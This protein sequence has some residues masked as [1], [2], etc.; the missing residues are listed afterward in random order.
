MHRIRSN[1]KSLILLILLSAGTLAILGATVLSVWYPLEALERIIPS[2]M[3]FLITDDE[4]K[5]RSL[6]ALDQAIGNEAY[7]SHE[8]TLLKV[9]ATSENL[10]VEYD[11]SAEKGRIP[12]FEC[13]SQSDYFSVMQLQ[14]KELPFQELADDECIL[15]KYRPDTEQADIGAK[16]TL[17][18]AGNDVSTVTVRETSLQNALSFGNSVGTLVV[19]DT[20]YHA[21]NQRSPEKIRV[22]SIDG[23]NMR[24]N[25]QAYLA[26]KEAIPENPYLVS[27]W[28]RQDELIRENSSTFL[29]IC[30]ATV[31]F[32][33]ATGS[34][35]YFQNISSVSYDK[36]DYEIMQRMGYNE[37]MI[38]KSVRRQVQTYYIIPYVIGLLHSIFAIT[39]YKS[40]L[41]D[42]LLGKSSAVLVPVLF[43]I[44]VF[45]A[46]Y[47]IYYQ[48]TKHSCYKIALN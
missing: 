11:I 3:E 6:D 33:I 37:S 29:L 26:L 48:L 18:V 5:Q 42:D 35:L 16:Y 7:Q 17:T 47:A 39:C 4:E 30:F 21:L 2:A 45:S 14:G 36:S 31:I 25:E 8:T 44:A 28:P 9:T 40:A 27:A 13:M 32:L 19:S 43:S 10:P 12:G 38:K 22:V 41:M 20:A 23:E 15:I 34:I 1:A 46:I 24:S